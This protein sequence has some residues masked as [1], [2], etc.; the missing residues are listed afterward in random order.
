M[1]PKSENQIVP[2]YI[3]SQTVELIIQ[4]SNFNQ[5]VAG[6]YQTVLLGEHET[7]LH[8]KDSKVINRS[9]IV[10]SL[11]T[12]GFYHLVLFVFRRK[13][14]SLLFFGI[15]CLVA[16]MIKVQN[17]PIRGGDLRIPTYRALL[18]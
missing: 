14:R 1:E 9:V 5:S 6:M 2:F 17:N 4:A 7:I 8:L 10:M 15:T 18:Y 13:E 12:I 3:K 11:L 16:A